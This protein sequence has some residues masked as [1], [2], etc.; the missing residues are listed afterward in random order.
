MSE[1]KDMSDDDMQAALERYPA[2]QAALVDSAERALYWLAQGLAGGGGVVAL[3]AHRRA[4]LVEM[5]RAY[6]P[7]DDHEPDEPEKS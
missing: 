7:D 3:I 4:E 1:D 6:E 2:L 5:G